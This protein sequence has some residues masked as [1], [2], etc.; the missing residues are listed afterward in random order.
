M[1]L[2]SLFQF[3]AVIRD[4]AYICNRITIGP[5]VTAGLSAAGSAAAIN[6]YRII[7]VKLNGFQTIQRHI[8][9]ARNMTIGIFLYRTY[10]QQYCIGR[11][12]CLL[13]SG[14][15]IRMVKKS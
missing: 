1:Q 10:I 13:N 5:Q 15:K 8:N 14:S 6:K 3:A 7:F 9:T 11:V 4:S 12:V 2:C